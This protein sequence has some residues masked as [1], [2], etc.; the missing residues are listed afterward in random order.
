[1]ISSI[2]ALILIYV[3]IIFILIAAIGLIRLPD[4]YTRMSASTKAVTFGTGFILL[5]VVIHFNDTSVM[6]KMFGI[7][8]FLL[9]SLSTAAHVI[10]LSAYKDQTKMSYLTFLD[11]LKNESAKQDA[12]EKVKNPDK[13]IKSEDKGE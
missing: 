11:E 1:M 5:G 12:P 9:F 2:I 6:L 7:F 13:E 8:I 3:G 10:G 4:V